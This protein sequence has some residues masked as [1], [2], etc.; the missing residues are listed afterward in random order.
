MSIL[1]TETKTALPLKRDVAVVGT[2]SPMRRFQSLP[3]HGSYGQET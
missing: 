3:K 1:V 2:K